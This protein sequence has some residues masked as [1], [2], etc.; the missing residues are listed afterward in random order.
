L[1]DGANNLGRVSAQVQLGVPRVALAESFDGVPGS[2]LPA[3]W[4]NSASGSTGWGTVSTTAQSPPNSAFAGDPAAISDSALTSPSI[5]IS[6]PA[7][8]VAFTHYYNLESG[9]EPFDGGVLEISLNNGPFID[10]TNAGGTFVSGAYDGRISTRYSSPISGRGAWSGNSGAFVNT[11]VNLPVTAAGQSIRLRWRLATDSSTGS[12][13]WYV[14]NISVRDG[15]SCCRSLIVPGITNMKQMNSTVL[16]SFDTVAG[17]TYITEYK[18]ALGTNLA[19]V[20]LQ[21]N[22]GDGSIKSVTN[23]TSGTTNR[24]FRV[25]TE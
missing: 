8:Q 5:G 12:V 14:D 25:R 6:N 2:G 15:F 17:Q 21:T 9:S 13:G 20:P 19:W 1:Q 23:L 11:V 22:S 3:G 24:F 10:I 16:F 18:N 7:A 4:V